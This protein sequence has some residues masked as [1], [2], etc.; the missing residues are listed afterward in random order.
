MSF[1]NIRIILV[2]PQ[3]AANTGAVARVMK[4]MGLRDLVLVRPR[5]RGRFWA[6]TMAVH[7][8][9]VLEAS[10]TCETLAEAVADCGL[11]AGTTC[12]QGPY[13]ATEH[14]PRSAAAELL[15]SARRNKVALVFGPED[16]GLSNKDIQLCQLVVTIPSHASY[17]S[18]N[19]ASAVGICCYELFVAGSEAAQPGAEAPVLA[20]SANT[21]R[22]YEHL[23]DSF[24]SIGFLLRDNPEHIMYAFRSMLG[25]ARL[26]DRDVRILLGLA[27]QIEWYGSRKSSMQGSKS[28]GNPKGETP[29]PSS[30]N[31]EP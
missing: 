25:R 31:P 11:I 30:P 5:F 10:R 1:D 29:T 18:L 12:R 28:E 9:D 21:E 6:K 24:L 22:M 19:L 4:N 27:R 20:T 8:S 16:H 2:R 15:C 13:R 7:A 17:P 14:T 23:Q 26:E 3:G